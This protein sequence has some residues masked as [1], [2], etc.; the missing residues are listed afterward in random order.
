MARILLVEDEPLVA[1]MV[2]RMLERAGHQVAWAASGQ[3][4]L[5][6]LA[7]EAQGFDLVVCDLVMPGV[8][9]VEVIREVRR[10]GGP[11]VLALSASVSAQSQEEALK[12]GAQAFLGKPFEGQALLAQVERLLQGTPGAAGP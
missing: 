12:A 2:R 4:A 6:R 5:E 1:H 10:R 7:Q 3:L 11:P 8:S 9:G